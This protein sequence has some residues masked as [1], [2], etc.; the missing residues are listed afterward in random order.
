MALT[1]GQSVQYRS[2]KGIP[3]AALVV[4]THDSISNQAEDA[5]PKIVLHKDADAAVLVFSIT[6]G[7]Y[8]RAVSE[9]GDNLV[10]QF[11]PHWAPDTVPDDLV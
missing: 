9:I 5:D 6:G 10:E 7:A 8:Y 3:K 2:L 11:I 1:V 4:I